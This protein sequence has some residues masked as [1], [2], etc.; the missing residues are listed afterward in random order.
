MLYF[1]SKPD[2]ILDPIGTQPLPP[3]L[4]GVPQQRQVRAAAVALVG[5][6]VPL[7]LN[8]GPHAGEP[9]GKNDGFRRS[10]TCMVPSAPEAHT[11]N[12]RYDRLASDSHGGA[13]PDVL[14]LTQDHSALIFISQIQPRRNGNSLPRGAPDH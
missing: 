13:H 9:A 2:I 12:I 11:A 6:R 3:V 7:K 4:F 5:S 1:G 8:S 10:R 14:V